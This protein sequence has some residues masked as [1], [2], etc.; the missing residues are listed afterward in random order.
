MEDD[1]RGR[2]SSGGPSGTP[3]W[4]K[5]SAMIAVA[6]AVLVLAHLLLR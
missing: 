6:L 5:V 3:R 2:A 4:V 1:E